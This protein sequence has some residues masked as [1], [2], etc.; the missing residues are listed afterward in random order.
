MFPCLSVVAF[1]LI[2]SSLIYLLELNPQSLNLFLPTRRYSSTHRT[3]VLRRLCSYALNHLLCCDV[4]TGNVTTTNSG[5]SNQVL[6]TLDDGDLALP[7]VQP[8]SLSLFASPS[9]FL[10]RK[11]LFFQFASNDDE[12]DDDDDDEDDKR[13]YRSKKTVKTLSKK[14]E[15]PSKNKKRDTDRD[16]IPDHLDEDD[17]HDAISDQLDDDD[18]GDGIPDDEDEDHED[19]D[20]SGG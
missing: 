8:E 18:D 4:H 11:L 13:R 16:G 20:D 6:L 3:S 19:F 17:D 5:Y 10:T 7:K 12:D 15:K 14:D 1:N 2:S 9:S